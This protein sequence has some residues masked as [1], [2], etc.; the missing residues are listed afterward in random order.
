MRS[1]G[2]RFARL[3]LDLQQR[4]FSWRSGLFDSTRLTFFRR[5]NRSV[6]FPKRGVRAQCLL[7]LVPRYRV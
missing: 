1:A 5:M 7:D 2:K 4:F 3:T 6:V